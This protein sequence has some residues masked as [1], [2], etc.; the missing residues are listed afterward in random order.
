M[1]RSGNHTR[2]DH[3]FTY[4]AYHKDTAVG[5][6]NLKFV[7][8][9]PKDRFLMYIAHVSWPRQVSSSYWCPFSSG[10]SA[11]IWPWRP[12]SFVS[13]EQCMLRCVCH[14]N[15]AKHLLWLQFLRLGTLMNLSSAAERT[16]SCGG[17][18]ES[19]FHHSAWFIFATALWTNV[20]SSQFSTLTDLHVLK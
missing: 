15:S 18:H 20:Q 13:S 5:T 10:F 7:L 12:N 11:A 19:Q 4:S 17:P 3:P 8:I 6:K 2:G 14:L 9:R 16:L 1:L